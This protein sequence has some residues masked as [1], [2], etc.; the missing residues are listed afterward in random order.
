MEKFQPWKIRIVA[1]VAK[2]GFV[3]NQKGKSSFEEAH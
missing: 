1:G 3:Q 2:K